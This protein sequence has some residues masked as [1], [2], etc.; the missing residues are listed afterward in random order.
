[1][2]QQRSIREPEKMDFLVQPLSPAWTAWKEEVEI[3]FRLA[4]AKED[5]AYQRDALLYLLGH[6]GRRI[7]TTLTFAKEEKDRTVGD[8]LEAF[9]KH[10]TASINVDMERHKFFS[11][12]QSN[13]TYDQYVTSLKLL[14]AT[15]DFGDKKESLV[16]TQLIFGIGDSTVRQRLLEG[17]NAYTLTKCI[18]VCKASEVSKERMQTMDQNVSAMGRSRGRQYPKR[19]TTTRNKQQSAVKSCWF[20]GGDYPHKGACPAEGQRCSNCDKMNHF[21]KCCLKQNNQN[22]K[23]AAHA[24]AEED[25][26][27]SEDDADDEEAYCFHIKNEAI[28]PKEE[29]DKSQQKMNKEEDDKI[30]QKMNKEE[31][32]K[33]K[34]KM[35]KEEDY[36]IKQKM[37]KEEDKI[38]QRMNKEDDKDN[39]RMNKEE[40]DKNNQRMNK[41]ED[42]KENTKIKDANGQPKEQD[43]CSKLRSQKKRTERPKVD[44]LF[45]DTQVNILIDTGSDPNVI[46]QK[47][48]KSLKNKPELSSK[49]KNVYPYGSKTPLE[50]LG[51]FHTKIK[52]K[53][54]EV[55]TSISV[56]K[57]GV[58]DLLGFATATQ[59]GLVTINYN[60]GADP[61]IDPAQQIMHQFQ[62]R[63]EG[64]GKLTG[65]YCKLHIDDNI[66]PVTQPHRRIPFHLRPK[67]KAELERLQALDIIEPVTDEPTPWISPITV[68]PKPRNP[69]EI[70]ICVDMRAPNKAVKR[71]RHVTP[72][73]D[74]IV[75]QLNGA[76]K[77]SKLDLNSGYHQVELDPK[78][79]Y[80][81]VFST[82]AGLFRYKRLN[83][84]LCSAAEKFQN[85]IQSALAGLNGVINISDDILVFGKT[86]AEHQEN[87]V[88]CL[89]RLR[90]RNLTLKRE[91]CE[92]FTDRIEFF[93]H[94]FSANGLSPDPKKVAALM[95]APDPQSVEEVRSLLG[96]A[97]YCS[98]F[99]PNLATISEPLRELTKASTPWTWEEKHKQALQQLKQSISA[100]CT[101][102]YFNPEHETEVVVDASPVGL[103]GMLVQ[104]DPCGNMS[105]VAL[106]SKALPEVAQRYSQTEREA[107]AVTWG[108]LHF[109]L[110][111]C[112]K[113]FKVIT[114]H[115]PLV[116][117]FNNPYSKPTARIERWLLKLQQYQFAVE[118]RPGKNNPSDFM[119]RH[120]QN[121]SDSIEQATEEHINLITTHAVPKNVTLKDIQQATTEDEILQLCITAINTNNWHRAKQQAPGHLQQEMDSLY[122][123]RHELSVV[124][125]GDIILRDHRI[126]IP[127]ALR[128][129]II[130]IAH[131]GHQGI[132]KT[133]QL[134]R[135]KVW[136]PGID[137]MVENTISQCMPCQTTTIDKSREPLT[138]SKLPNG[139]WL[140]VSIDFADLPTGEH[141]LVVYDDYS[142][143]PEVEITTSTS[144][145]AVIPKLD[146]IFSA[147]GVPSIVRTDNGPPFNSEQFA[148]FSK[149]LGFQHR[150]VTPLW[151]RANG[152]VER[153]M[154][155]LKKQYRTAHV[156]NIPWKQALYKFLRNYRATPHTTT[157]VPPANLLFGR[158]V[159]TRLPELQPVPSNDD[160][161]RIR[162]KTAKDRMKANADKRENVKKKE[163]KVGDSV[164]VKRD[165]HSSKDQTPYST[166]IYT[167]IKKKGTMITASSAM[168]NTITRNSSFFKVINIDP[169]TNINPESALP[170]PPAQDPPTAAPQDQDI[171]VNQPRR[172]P[173]RNRHPPR[174]FDDF[175]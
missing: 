26:K 97:T 153:F 154:K 157:G 116:P 39:Q 31:D 79:R 115:K 142:R 21:A 150:R 36:K 130:N 168:G 131:E 138:M 50:M 13:E 22:K 103:G 32:D 86:D 7:Y 55:T 24:V 2:A 28:R 16:K 171:D 105:L 161:V 109:H 1:M 104:Y 162:D 37:N 128:Q 51:V 133:K 110:Y 96:M 40:D 98:R 147:F 34:Q 56:S 62:D 175:I 63:F 136:F 126:I 99:I 44:V 135:T 49:E 53:D 54:R 85:M 35:N 129:P 43:Q 46:C 33:N 4:L 123:I 8:I 11:R 94:I 17:G 91:K 68:V 3:Y 152:E 113:D 48:F 148:E 165:G 120:P 18:E 87:L 10:C 140:E 107:L 52:Y 84:G 5:A 41:E 65:A 72:T 67:V 59:L 117:L 30:K 149:Y 125:T 75:A 174:R 89:E 9:D 151:P 78:S 141:L 170:D 15:C 163:I 29:D 166:T 134:L 74:D 19:K 118:Y 76:V 69:E 112:G 95:D 155:T 106:A 124:S 12:K 144:A 101:M 146:K 108:I 119:S 159:R 100:Q 83:F 57:H 139:P 143:Y 77:F 158:S 23:K 121:V 14:A 58:E 47:T 60:I 42:K 27:Q 80:I 114:D 156:D 82:N 127:S 25:D 38:K 64:I 70:R 102:A 6:D 169:A 73:M 20:C 88:A 90:Q 173:A 93:G 137:S 132:V 45:Q 61:S 111:V 81:T 172:N 66:Q 160:A 164:I 145:R 122:Q 167:V 71:E 92:F